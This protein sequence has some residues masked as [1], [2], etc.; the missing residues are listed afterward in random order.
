MKLVF[1]CVV[2]LMPWKVKRIL[3]N[4]FFGYN[5]H[6]NAYIGFSWIFPDHLAMEERAHIDHF[7]VAIHLD[8]INMKKES[9]ISRSNWITGFSSKKQSPHF[10]HDVN[11]KSQLLMGLGAAIT[12]KHHIDCTSPIEIGAFSTI[13]GYQSQLLT[14]S[15]NIYTNRQESKKIVIGEYCFV[16]SGVI[17][18]GGASLPSYSV[19]GAKS[20]LNKSFEDSYFLYAG[21]PALPIKKISESALYFSRQTPF[22]V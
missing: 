3:L 10:S 17:I 19:L 2:V 14:H 22:V 9:T 15:I 18:L 12:K 13:A 21:N 8:E 11:R 1:K 20:L 7:N 6:P 5:L 16:G 4:S